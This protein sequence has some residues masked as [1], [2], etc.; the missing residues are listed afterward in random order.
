MRS[1]PA[2]GCVDEAV[3]VDVEHG[4]WLGSNDEVAGPAVRTLAGRLG[5]VELVQLRAGVVAHEVDQ[6]H[7]LE[8]LS[9]AVGVEIGATMLA[10]IST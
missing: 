5:G 1:G 10:S 2:F 6:A 3:A 7:G 8:R 4:A 9:G